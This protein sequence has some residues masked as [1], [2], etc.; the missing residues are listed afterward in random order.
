MSVLD[1]AVPLLGWE[2]LLEELPVDPVPCHTEI[3]PETG[4]EPRCG[5]GRVLRVSVGEPGIRDTISSCLLFP[6]LY[7]FS[8]PE[9]LQVL[10]VRPGGP[11]STGG[12]SF[13][14]AW[15]GTNIY[16]MAWLR[17]SNLSGTVPS[18]SQTEDLLDT[19]S[20][21][22]DHGG[23]GV[24]EEGDSNGDTSPSSPPA[25]RSTGVGVTNPVSDTSRVQA[26]PTSRR[27][28]RH[29]HVPSE[30]PNVPVGGG[31]S[32]RTR[33]G[34]NRTSFEGDSFPLCT[35]YPG[36]MVSWSPNSC[37][38]TRLRYDEVLGSSDTPS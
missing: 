25:V 37:P 31:D 36:T 10:D 1:Q 22:Q 9:P 32:G 17:T 34:G 12:G 5:S 4:M 14:G 18:L 30:S 28:S 7:L 29:H 6:S 13:S 38:R 19:P 11:C 35:R 15:T 26:G 21:L 16:T 33:D 20:H 2:P 24:G 3:R 23:M 27:V 8:T